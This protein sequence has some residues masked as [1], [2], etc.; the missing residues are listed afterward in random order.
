VNGA[1]VQ[2]TLLGDD[3]LSPI[4]SGIPA[5]DFDSAASDRALTGDGLGWLADMLAVP[6][7]PAC[8][9]CGHLMSL[10]AAAPV[11]W[12]CPA[13]HPGEAS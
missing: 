2:V 11:L 1:G 9:R 5:G 10:P 6:Q 12:A 13:C 8:E 4:I 7:P 3:D